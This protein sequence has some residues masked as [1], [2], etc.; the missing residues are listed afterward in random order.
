MGSSGFILDKLNWY[1]SVM[2]AHILYYICM[3]NVIPIFELILFF[4]SN[5][6]LYSSK[7]NV[8]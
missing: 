2:Y 7:N 6:S 5:L 3:Y 1:K 4:F 8:I